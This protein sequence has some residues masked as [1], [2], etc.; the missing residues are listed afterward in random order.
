MAT[1]IEIELIKNVNMNNKD[2]NFVI[3][4]T[5]I[6]I[7]LSLISNGAEGET[8]K[9]ILQLLNYKNLEEA[10]NIS[11]E[12][13]EQARKD[14]DILSIA[15]AVL[16]KVRAKE[17]F[18]RKGSKEYD[19]K[20]EELKNFHQVNIW[21]KNKTKNNI[22]NIIDSISPKVLMILL[23]A[24]YFEAFW[25]IPFDPKENVDREF[26][27][28]DDEANKVNVSMMF[29]SG[30]LLN[31]YEND[32][33]QSVKLNYETKNDS[34]NAIIILP[35]ENINFYIKHFNDKN[36]E[37]II[38]GLKKEKKKVNLFLPKFEVEYKI[39]LNQI[40][41]DL[42]IKKAFTNDAE[43]KNICDKSPIHIG[44]VIQKNY[45]NVNEK[46]TQAASVTQL[47]VILE[48]FKEGD[49]EAIN[50]IAN[51][52]FIFLLVNEKFPKGHDILFFTKFCKIE[53][54]DDY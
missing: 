11:K 37:E 29:L 40:L 39:D 45:I 22:V 35:K 1:N 48:S 17:I 8:Q 3:S 2:E 15:T 13:I 36:Y 30:Q 18:I 53:V 32:F 49:P 20:I 31:Y 19:A 27:N 23:N 51:K 24:I 4:P 12:L 43:F 5:G 46:G 16:T 33:I 26:Y 41:I 7:V 44:Q 50:F 28:L 52:P 6:E 21:A 34:I 47:D 14:K 54:F 42:G 9:E 25:K 10:N 38:D